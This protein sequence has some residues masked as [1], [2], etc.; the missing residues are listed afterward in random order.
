MEEIKCLEN[1]KRL[2]EMLLAIE[3]GYACYFSSKLHVSTWT[4]YRL[5]AYLKEIENLDVKYDS[6]SCAYYEVVF[7]QS[8]GRREMFL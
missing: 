3:K 6:Y 5:I 4:F 2:R 8:L 7:E 1:Y